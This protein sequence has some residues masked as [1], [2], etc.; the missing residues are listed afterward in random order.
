MGFNSGFKGLNSF[1]CIFLKLVFN[2][3]SRAGKLF[4]FCVKLDDAVIQSFA[5]GEVMVPGSGW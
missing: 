4:F 3:I 1:L 5:H 2:I